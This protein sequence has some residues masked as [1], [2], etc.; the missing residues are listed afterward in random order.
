[1]PTSPV[2]VSLGAAVAC[3]GY[4]HCFGLVGL[5]CGTVLCCHAD[6]LRYPYIGGRLIGFL[7]LIS[8]FLTPGL[9][10]LLEQLTII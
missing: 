9:L 4:S 2:H 5:V 6:A 1:M 8:V 7:V 3:A 10:L